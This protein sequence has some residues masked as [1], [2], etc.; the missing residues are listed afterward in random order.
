MK[1]FV[2]TG[3]PV[4]LAAW[5]VTVFMTPIAIQI[6]LK[7]NIVDK[8]D[9][10]KVHQKIIPRI[11]GIAIVVGFLITVLAS[12]P[13]D[14][15][16]TGIIGGGIVIAIIGIW[17][18]CISLNP[19]IKLLGQ[20]VAASI[21]Y[22]SGVS[23]H[24]AANPMGGIVNLEWLAFPVTVFWI[25]A[26]INTVNLI[27][28]LD[29]LAAGLCGISSLTVAVLMIAQ[30]Q[31]IPAILALALTGNCIGFLGYNFSPARVFMGDVG[32]MFLGYSLAVITIYGVLKSTITASLLIPIVI[33]GIPIADTAFAIFRR[34]R[35][36][37]GI[38]QPDRGHFHHILLDQ[39]YNHRQAVLI[40]YGIGMVLALLGF[41]FGILHYQ[42]Q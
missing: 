5:L 1:E 11:G 27:D 15:P 25:V 37:K 40:F 23:I 3:L 29:G 22:F 34:V 35:S 6:A 16:I 13:I 2:S 30:D 42:I 33:L 41:G 28:G 18:D 39:G 32:S 38:F 17:D 21:P 20:L 26:M 31:W 7:F 4:F 12:V 8:P 24:F 19:K 36:G 9:T 14:G 10:R